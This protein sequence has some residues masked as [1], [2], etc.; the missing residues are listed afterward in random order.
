MS[1]LA[2]RTALVSG[3]SRGIGLEVARAL[4]ADGM[5]VAM[6]ARS[7]DELRARASEIGERAIPIPCDVADADAVGALVQ[8]AAREFG[9]A[10]D[11]IVNNAGNFAL[12]TVE[13]T[14]PKA[15]RAAID[16]NLVAP[17]VLAHA[18]LGEM[19]QRKGGHMTLW[20]SI[21]TETHPGFTPRAQMLSARAVAEAV[22][23]AVSLPDDV[24]VDELRLSRS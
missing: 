18:F 2:G 20:D 22:R 17:F 21:D 1:R 9:G 10:P 4:A 13:A 7:A 3:A 19:R 6:V 11:V 23:Y 12:A 14:E 15:F 24:N 16:V 5:R 8:R